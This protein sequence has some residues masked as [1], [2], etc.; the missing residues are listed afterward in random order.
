MFWYK[1][2]K[3]IHTKLF[4]VIEKLKTELAGRF[5]DNMDNLRKYSNRRFLEYTQERKQFS[6]PPGNRRIEDSDA[7]IKLNITQSMCDTIK[8]KITKNSP[9]PMF[10]TEGGDYTLQKRAKKMGQFVESVF[11]AEDFYNKIGRAFW[12]STIM[13][14]GALKIFVEDNHI[15]FENVMPNELLVDESECVYSDPKCLYQIK[16]VHRDSLIEMFP[17]KEKEISFSGQKTDFENIVSDQVQVVEAWYIGS[18][19]NPGRHVIAL[20]DITLLDEEY[21]KSYFPFV[22]LRWNPLTLS[23]YGQSLAEQLKGIQIEINKLLKRIQQSMHLLAVPFV[24][25]EYGSK[26]KPNEIQNVPGT[27]VYY[28]NQPPQVYTPQTV[29]PEVFNHLDRLYQRAYEITGI[30]ELS[31]QGKKPAGLESGIALRT[32]HDIETERFATIARSYE[33]ACLDASKIVVDLAKDI[34]ASGGKFSEKV[35]INKQIE[36]IDWSEV[37]L[38]DDQYVMR[39]FPVSLLPSTP[40]GKLQMVQEMSNTGL[41]DSKEDKFKLLDFPDLEAF[42][43]QVNAGEDNIQWVIEEIMER[44]IYHTPEPTQNLQLGVYMVKNAYL[45]AMTTGVEDEKRELLLQWINEA[46]ALLAPAQQQIQPV[47][48]SDMQA[49]MSEPIMQG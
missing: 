25:M 16:Y 22:F 10:L 33:K 8:S 2:E 15:R 35:I 19:S 5:E 17:E 28:N 44:N 14:I 18:G 1:E 32:M 40:E 42:F 49:Q 4:L 31:A 9:R 48:Q 13:D 47:P 27:F 39:I 3:E 30:S 37:S 41:L 12:D 43:R 34:S 21:K 29:N 24:F 20:E 46:I 7:D 23:F 26:V 38:K 11:L 36:S 6:K 45:N